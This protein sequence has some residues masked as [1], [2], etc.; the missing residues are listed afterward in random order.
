[1]P[2]SLSFC[3]NVSLLSPSPSSSSSSSS[4]LSVCVS[5]PTRVTPSSKTPIDHIYSTNIAHSLATRC[6]CNRRQRP[7]PHLPHLVKKRKKKEKKGVK[8]PKVGHSHLKYR[9]L[10]R[11]DES[12]FLNDLSNAPFLIKHTIILIQTR[13]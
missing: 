6:A 10:A 13:R 5:T 9:S 11:F 12:E 3:N 4:P 7:L 2:T 1:M 8:I